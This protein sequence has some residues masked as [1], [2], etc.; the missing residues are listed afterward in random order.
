MM[1]HMT[2]AP[3][4]LGALSLLLL[5]ACKKDNEE[6]PAAGGGNGSSTPTGCQATGTVTDIDGNVYP[7]VTIGSQQWMAAN[8]RTTRYR[9]GS[10][11]PNVTDSAAWSALATGAWCN[12]LNDPAND[13]LYG[14]LYNWY[15]AAA[16]D[17]CPAGWHL[18][19]DA[20]WKQLET[21]LGMPASEVDLFNAS[22]GGAQNVGGK[23]KAATL[24][25]APNT[26]ATDEV[27]F[28]AYA[29]GVRED[30]DGAFMAMGYM[31]SW[32]SA[33]PWEPNPTAGAY[34]RF[35]NYQYGA[36]SRTVDDFR[37]GRCVRCV[38]D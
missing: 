31:G 27:C 30:E 13:T 22:R 36:I 3:A 14:K 19:T 10:P 26:G 28:A 1:R 2:S 12:Y 38:R 5:I 6:T 21:T 23:L 37:T 20:E 18:P 11:V 9:D 16:P 4:L 35:L 24:W 7:V 25:L 15:A 34:Y 17:L 29:T 33:T 8:L 32:W